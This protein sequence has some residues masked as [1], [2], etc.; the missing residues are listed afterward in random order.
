[1]LHDDVILFCRH[2]LL[3]GE[4]SMS[5]QL[6]EPSIPG[7]DDSHATVRQILDRVTILGIVDT[8]HLRD[9]T[10]SQRDQA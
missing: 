1:M 8:D 7:I 9:I 2:I 4:M 6:N 10:R 5:D 3:Q